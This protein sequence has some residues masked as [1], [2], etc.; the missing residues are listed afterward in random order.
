MLGFLMKFAEMRGW[1]NH[2]NMGINIAHSAKSF[3]TPE[4]RF[5]SATY[6]LRTTFGR[7]ERP[8]GEVCWRVLER[9]NRY[10]EEANQHQLLD[11][12][13]PVLVTCFAQEARG[14]NREGNLV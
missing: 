7:F 13:A 14:P 12:P 4:P 9:N 1:H 5:S 6:P 8:T 11:Q 3:R 2:K 10:L